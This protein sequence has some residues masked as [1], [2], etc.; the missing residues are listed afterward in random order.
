MLSTHEILETFVGFLPAA[1]KAGGWAKQGK[2]PC[3]GLDL[4]W[5]DPR[6]QRMEVGRERSNAQPFRQRHGAYG[7]G[8]PL[9]SPCPEAAPSPNPAPPEPCVPCC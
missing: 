7:P 4:D 1:G 9:P 8:C 6:A 5:Q 3:H 2:A